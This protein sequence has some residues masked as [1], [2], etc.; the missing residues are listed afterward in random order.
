MMSRAELRSK[1]EWL[2]LKQ[3][4]RDNIVG[5]K[6]TTD[7]GRCARGNRGLSR[8]RVVLRTPL[9]TLPATHAH[10]QVRPCDVGCIIYDAISAR[11][12]FF[13]LNKR[14]AKAW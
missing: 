14:R 8:M 3:Q 10:T 2:E 1:T 11:A 5:C 7:A 13:R 12:N 9:F 6:T 4:A